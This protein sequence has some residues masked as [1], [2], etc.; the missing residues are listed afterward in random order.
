MSYFDT[1]LRLTP[2]RLAARPSSP[3]ASRRGTCT[4][5]SSSPSPPTSFPHTPSSAPSAAIS[6]S[7]RCTS[8]TR[9]PPASG[10][11]P[12]PAGKPQVGRTRARP[13]A[14]RQ[15]MTMP[16]TSRERAG[17]AR[18]RRTRRSPSRR[19]RSAR[20]HRAGAHGL[21][22]RTRCGFCARERTAVRRERAGGS[23]ATR[24]SASAE[25]GWARGGGSRGSSRAARQGR[26]GTRRDRQHLALH[27]VLP[28]SSCCMCVDSASSSSAAIAPRASSRSNLDMPFRCCVLLLGE[29]G[30]ARK[31]ARASR[32]EERVQPAHAER[33]S[34]AV[35]SPDTD[36]ARAPFSSETHCLEL[37]R[38]LQRLEASC[39]HQRRPGQRRARSTSH[40]RRL[41]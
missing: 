24:A 13:S 5:S 6:G 40:E 30:R 17:A 11:P 12:S 26:R 28:G 34:T 14:R 36:R 21:T 18:A 35:V 32:R 23:A 8:P 20:A 22:R 7:G 33:A 15:Q 4:S 39:G 41:R 27:R 25:S 9:T 16:R 37:W 2:P 3:L 1:S 19:R 31:S 29:L 38:P 10:T